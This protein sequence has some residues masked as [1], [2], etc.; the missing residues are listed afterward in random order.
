MAL[1]VL[2]R[3]RGAVRLGARL[4]V[5]LALATTL[6]GCSFDLGSLSTATDK[7]EAPRAAP[8]ASNVAEAQAATLRAQ[9]LAR[10]GKSK[11]ALAE[12][13]QAIETDPNNAQALYGRGK[14]DQAIETDPNNAQALYGRGLLYQGEKQYQS[15]VDDFTS[16]TG[17][18]PQLAEP[19]LGRAASYL[20]LDKIKEAT[21]D[22]DEAAQAEPQ[23]GEIW[24]MRGLAYERLGDRTRAAESY[25]RAIQL[26]PKDE[27]SRIGYT[28]VGGKSG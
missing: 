9:V 27:A 10:S 20:A 14:F 13:D 24:A 1:P 22:L 26:R 5:A 28:R 16:A 4:A 17:L 6:W 15:A 25:G 12:F 3:S 23:N 19:L 8:A 18:R 2:D 11:E 21:A 7:T